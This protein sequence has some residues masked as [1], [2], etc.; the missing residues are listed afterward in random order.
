MCPLATRAEGRTCFL[1]NLLFGDVFLGHKWV[2]VEEAGI[3]AVKDA[4]TESLYA[5]AGAAGGDEANIADSAAAAGPA[6]GADDVIMAE[7]DAGFAA[8]GEDAATAVRAVVCGLQAGPA[9]PGVA[10]DTVCRAPIW[11]NVEASQPSELC[12][13]CSTGMMR[14]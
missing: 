12:R 10:P 8:I 3:R 1:C 6:D 14:S 5:K 2:D 7:T 13:D 11:R 4:E 9:C